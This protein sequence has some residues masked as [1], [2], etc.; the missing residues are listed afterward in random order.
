MVKERALNERATEKVWYLSKI[1]L[2]QRTHYETATL[3]SIMICQK[4]Y[5]KLQDYQAM[6][7]MT[8]GAV[9]I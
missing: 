5:I 6:R 7:N 8:Y 4:S 3:G 9:S 1:P 2:C